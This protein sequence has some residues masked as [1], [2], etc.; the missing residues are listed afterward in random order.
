MLRLGTVLTIMALFYFLFHLGWAFYV[1]AT[2][3]LS[4]IFVRLIHADLDNRDAIAFTNKLVRI[5]QDELKILNADFKHFYDGSK[6]VPKDHFYA[7]DMDVVGHASL[8]QYLNRT[9]SEQG[10][11]RMAQWLLY[12]AVIEDILR[13]QEATTAAKNNLTWVQDW[14]AMGRKHRI[15]DDMQRRLQKWLDEPLAFDGFKHWRWLRYILPAIIISICLLSFFD[16]LSMGFFYFSLFIYSVLAYQVNKVVAPIHQKLGSMADAMNVLSALIKHLEYAE[17]DSVL[18]KQLQDD[19]KRNSEVKASNSIRMLSRILGRLDLRYNLIVSFPLNVLLCWSLQQVLDLERWKKSHR[20][21]IK[22]WFEVLAEVEALNCLTVLD[23]NH[24]EWVLP[25]IAPGYFEFEAKNLGHP[26][27]PTGKRVNNELSIADRDSVH[28]ITG[29][30][31]GGKSTFLRSVGVNIVLA[32]AGAKVCATYFRVSR[33]QLMSSM[34]IAD[35]L[36][37]STS[38]F[39]AEL[40]KLKS[41]IEEVNDGK[42]IFVLLD[43][44]LRGTN[45]FDR[46]AG[47]AALIKQFIN[48]RIPAVLATHDVEL[49][50]LQSQYPHEIHNAHFDVQVSGEELYF[51]YKLK[52]GICTSMNASILMK[53]IGIKIDE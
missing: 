45:S 42:E 21:N 1:P 23:F 48:N 17:F 43:E 15:D 32:M 3:F 9:T 49:A 25:E 33:V 46:H 30:N 51:D 8:F 36:E 40:K 10:E 29:S 28:L 50:A 14:M 4:F 16:F 53:K 24:P 6:Q 18:W 5:Q 2:I 35:N 22:I 47:S 12:S 37:E 19:L 20:E 11:N 44:I 13:R 27:I 41:I 38:T 26:L 52:P 39:Y 34:R 31:M 7:N